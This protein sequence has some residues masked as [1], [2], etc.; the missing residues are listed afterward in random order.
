MTDTFDRTTSF[1]Q[2][3][4]KRVHVATPPE[5]SNALPLG[6]RASGFG[7]NA[8]RVRSFQEEAAVTPELR[9][10]LESIGM[11]TRF[12][13]NRGYGIPPSSMLNS[14]VMGGPSSG[15]LLTE[16]EILHHVHAN[17]SAFARTQSA[18]LYANELQP[19]AG[20]GMR[21]MLL[22]TEESRPIDSMIDEN[23]DPLAAAFFGDGED[24]GVLPNSQSST[25]S[26]LK[27]SRDLFDEDQ[28]H[29]QVA[30]ST[31]RQSGFGTSRMTAS[32]LPVGAGL[33]SYLANNS[34]FSSSTD[35]SAWKS[36]DFSQTENF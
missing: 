26:D 27:R 15:V 1:E 21:P 8:Q 31:N 4:A 32:T 29:E 19:F 7:E 18:P 30:P 35:A 5:S 34:I 12:N 28:Q 17:R 2:P 14:S 24:E 36:L 10:K 25:T 3:A 6:E 13:V 22:S 33:T 9:S 11:R 23:E 20:N 16:R